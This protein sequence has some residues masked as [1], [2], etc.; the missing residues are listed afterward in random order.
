MGLARC[1]ELRTSFKAMLD[2]LVALK[3]REQSVLL[4]FACNGESDLAS[5]GRFQ[6]LGAPC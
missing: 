3:P 1:E 5:L 4:N 2:H 6:V